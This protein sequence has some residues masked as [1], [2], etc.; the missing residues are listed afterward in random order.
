MIQFTN[1]YDQLPSAFF[2][3]VA[4]AQFPEGSLILLNHELAGDLGLELSGLSPDELGQLFTGQQIPKSSNPIATAYAGHQFGNFVPQ[5]GDGRALLLGEII[6]PEDQR[7]D[8]QLKGS[9]DTPYSRNGDGRSSLG[10]VI[11]EYLVSEAMHHLGAPTT[12]ALAACLSGERVFREKPL[13]GGVFTRVASSHIRIGTFEY[14]AHMGNLESLKTLL[15]YSIDRHYPSLKNAENKALAFLEEV[16]MAQAKM[17]ASW[18]SF[19][20]I[21]GVMNTD[22]MSI[23]GE[24][25]DFGPCAFM[26]N[27]AQSRVFSSIDRQ[28]R[29][30]YANQIPVAK[31]NL[32]RLASCLIPLVDDNEQIATSKIQES[33]TSYLHVYEDQW[34][35]KMAKKLGLFEVKGGDDEL[36]KGF[37]IYLEEQDL[38]FTLSFRE[39]GSAAATP[40]ENS[41]LLPQS[42]SLL[43][44]VEKWQERLK[45]QKQSQ[46]ESIALMDSVNPIFIPRN[47]KVEEAIV[48]A[49]AGDFAPFETFNKVLKT[50]FTSQPEFDQ[51]QRPPKPEERIQ[52]TFCGT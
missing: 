51:Y 4:P 5:L 52:A 27:F 47:H 25:L 6:S 10:P 23:S 11:R 43:K 31:W 26:D 24:T 3:N 36:V 1:S 38:D 34:L 30:A 14:F 15:D 33:L 19:G 37:L 28:G 48:A 17:V 22:N 42:A 8:I 12:R 32:Y 45:N 2:S 20:F 46:A 41:E 18:A 44:F 16:A 9:G 40:I 29:Y 49:I 50:P 7:F 13:P 21:H 35:E 39:L